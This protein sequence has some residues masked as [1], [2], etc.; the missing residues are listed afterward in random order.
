MNRGEV[1]FS[2]ICPTFNR[3]KLLG[4]AINSV[5]KQQHANFE[6][7]IVN[8]GSTDNTRA[9]VQSYND[10]RIVYL[11]HDNNRGL[12][13]ALNTGLQKAKGRYIAK[14]DDDDELGETAVRSAISVYGRLRDSR[15][16]LLFF[17]CLDV[18]TRL[19]SG[20]FLQE[21]TIIT[22]EDLLCQKLSGD[23]WAVVETSILPPRRLLDEYSWGAM[24]VLW[25]RLL[26][27]WDAYYVPRIVYYAYRKH[28]MQR[29]THFPTSR[30]KWQVHEHTTEAILNEFGKD[31]KSRCAKAY[32]KQVATLAFYQLMNKKLHLARLNLILSLR[33]NL[34]IH[35]SGLLL[36]TF[37]GKER[38]IVFLYEHLFQNH[39]GRMLF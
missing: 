34:S 21:E 11:E 29:L 12:N 3:S 4:R 19:T 5:L 25:L 22:Y 35:A 37:L 26:R 10:Q 39:L 27:D 17:N 20:K 9:L 14:L 16:R 13:A 15:I 7:I 24:G 33:T 23:Y 38:A 1:L 30:E 18:E 36:L 8:D 31:M 28:D 2:I 6:L 32:S